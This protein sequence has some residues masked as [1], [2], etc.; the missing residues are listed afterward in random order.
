MSNCF[1]REVEH[2]PNPTP[3]CSAHPSGV[4]TTISSSNNDLTAQWKSHGFEKE[5]EISSTKRIN[6][7]LDPGSLLIRID[8]SGNVE[9]QDILLAAIF[10]ASC[11]FS[12]NIQLVNCP[13]A[14]PSFAVDSEQN[15]TCHTG[16]L[17]YPLSSRKCTCRAATRD[18][19]MGY[20]PPKSPVHA[21]V[22][23]PFGQVG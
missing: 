7:M 4:R 21:I 8:G 3:C 16:R 13:P 17:K 9:F 22:T 6:R 12:Q 18:C 20:P 10:Q 1:L 15:K 14:S 23:G 11:L 5:S 19:K 2:M